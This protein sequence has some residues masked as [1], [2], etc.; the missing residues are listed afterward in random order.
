MSPYKS[1]E[2]EQ[3]SLRIKESWAS[4]DALMLKVC[5]IEDNAEKT[6]ILNMIGA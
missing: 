2:L 5:N 6:R 3:V 1:S 4:I